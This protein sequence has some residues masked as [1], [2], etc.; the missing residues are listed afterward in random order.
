[1]EWNLSSLT[2]WIVANG[3]RIAVVIVA[4]WLTILIA[5]RFI[6]AMGGRLLE[7]A[8]EAEKIEAQKR[9]QTLTSLGRPVA[10][11]TI[12]A[13]AIMV[14]L[15]QLGINLGPIL[16]AAGI[17]G[18]AVGFGA[19]SLVKDV[20]SGLFILIENQFNVGDVIQAAGMAGL[21]ERSNLRVTVLRDLEG[22]VHYIPNGQISV[23]SNLTKN[24]SRALLNIGVA[25]KEDTDRVTQILVSVGEDLKND[26]DFGPKILEPIEIFGVN[27][28][29]DSAVIILAGIKTKPIQQWS[30]AREFRRRIKKA[31]DTEGIE[32]PFP[33]RTIYMGEAEN[34][35]RLNVIVNQQSPLAQDT[36][37]N[38]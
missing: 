15:G 37:S 9:I 12:L 31:F 30:V 20:I 8:A 26:P 38:R 10:T 28:F 17:L 22:K 32:I 27:D 35:G 5:R 3:L 14:V 25:Y 4:A 36:E 11:F 1:M 24:W 23:L 18:L 6:G 16:A 19:Q 33:H 7:R 29:A 13:V 2:A 21:V 34:K